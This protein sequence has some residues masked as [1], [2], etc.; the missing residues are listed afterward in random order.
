VEFALVAPVL[1]ILLVGAR[2]LSVG[3]ATWWHVTQAAKAIG[4]I[5]T[6]TA[7]NTDQ[8][9]SLTATEAY[10]AATA[11]FP[12]LPQ[13][14]STAAK[15]FGVV[16]SA[17]VFTPTAAVV[18]PCTGACLYAAAVAW[19][20]VPLGGAAARPCG[21]LT[22]AADTAAPSPTTLPASAFSAAPLLVVDLSVTFRPIFTSLLAAAIPLTRTVYLPLRTGPDSAWVR[23]V[24]TGSAQPMC[25][26]FS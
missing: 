20:H 11:V 9:N 2:D 8:T 13:L 12:L 4:Q 14:V 25:P 16:L 23:Y 26:G 5:A 6:A 10:A 22:Q 1:V 21:A 3:I 18:T 17:V 7:A 19:S 24:D 15:D